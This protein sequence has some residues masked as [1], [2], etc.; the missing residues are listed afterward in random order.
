MRP[1]VIAARM[2]IA[3]H[4]ATNHASGMQA[5]ERVIIRHKNSAFPAAA[6]HFTPQTW[7][8]AAQP[9]ALCPSKASAHDK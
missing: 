5:T 6:K 4:P 9:S 2:P 7:V 3:M 1:V 8:E